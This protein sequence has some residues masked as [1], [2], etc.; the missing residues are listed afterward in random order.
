[1][2]HLR[3]GEKL[4]NRVFHFNQI[5]KLLK[6]ASASER[7]TADKADDDEDPLRFAPNPGALVSKT[8]EEEEG[9]DGIYRPPKMLPTSM[10]Y[11]TG[12]RDAKELR[13]NKE[14]R[15]RASR[16]QLIK[17][18][19]A[20][21]D[22]HVKNFVR[23]FAP[24]VS[25]REIVR[26]FL[27][28]MAKNKRTKSWAGCHL[29][30]ICEH[31][32]KS[33][34]FVSLDIRVLSPFGFFFLCFLTFVSIHGFYTDAVF[35]ARRNS[36]ERLAKRRKRLDSATKIWRKARSPS[37]KLLAWKLALA[38]KKICL[39]A[40]RFPSKSED[41]KRRPREMS[42]RSPPSETLATMSPISSNA[43]RS[44]TRALASAVS[45]TPSRMDTSRRLATSLL[46]NKT[47][48]C[49]TRSG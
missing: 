2:L 27:F 1:M 38:S 10:D 7:A 35:H 5:D 41:A 21:Y 4:T 37:A 46:E 39:R 11:D 45:S 6:L 18:R 12:G 17:V 24:R 19:R 40:Y 9:G 33:W 3:H 47:C 30:P 22:A 48:P 25:F 36:P 13:R 32:I 16:S 44:W 26:G 23:L 34:T 8:G 15:R 29:F 49:A 20:S 14:Q 42:T 43:R 28:Y 31:P